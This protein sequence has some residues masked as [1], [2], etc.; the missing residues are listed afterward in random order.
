MNE[1]I[2]GALDAVK[3]RWRMDKTVSG[4][5]VVIFL[6]TSLV[7][8]FGNIAA[9]VWMARGFVAD[10]EKISNTQALDRARIVIL[11]AARSTEGAEKMVNASRMAVL[12]N[13]AVNTEA[14][15]LRVESDVKKLL[16]RRG[17]P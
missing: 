15:V 5:T 16:E 14:A 7:A 2:P 11:E 17:Q 13:R 9:M 4:Q 8:A 6:I 3:E 1:T 12:E 10:V